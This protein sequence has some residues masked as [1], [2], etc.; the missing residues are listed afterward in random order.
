M[1]LRPLTTMPIPNSS[2]R[3]PVASLTRLSPSKM[4]TMRCGSPTRFAMEV[5]A[6]A[7]VVATTAPRTKPS[8][9]LKPGNTHGAVQATPRTVNTTSPIAR[10]EMLSKLNLNS[11]QEVSQA[12]EYSKRRQDYQKNYV[13]IQRDFGDSGK[14]AEKQSGDHQD[15]RIGS[16]QLACEHREH[17]DERQQHDENNFDCVDSAAF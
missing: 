9:Q 15:N 1:E 7:S 2:A 3:S 12:A 16:L 10:N 11:R 4:S 5:A 13:G 8:C 17:H 6:I 14:Q